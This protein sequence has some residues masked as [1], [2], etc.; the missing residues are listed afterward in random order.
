M[1]SNTRGCLDS[2]KYWLSA[3]CANDDEDDFDF[4]CAFLM[5]IEFPPNL[6]PVQCCYKEFALISTRFFGEKRCLLRP[7]EADNPN[8][9]RAFKAG[10]EREAATPPAAA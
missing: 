4:P 5:K 7:A 8:P 9:I 10:V 6:C 1:G 3:P 2:V